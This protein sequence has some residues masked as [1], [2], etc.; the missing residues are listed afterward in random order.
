MLTAYPNGT[1]A[2]C[3]QENWRLLQR[4]AAKREIFFEEDMIIKIMQVLL[5][6]DAPSQYTNCLMVSSDLIHCMRPLMIL[7][8]Q[9][10]PLS[11]KKRIESSKRHQCISSK[12]P[13]AF[14]D[15]DKWQDT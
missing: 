15:P 4:V 9:H 7:A 2:K 1:S 8:G 3:K 14:A 6:S 12:A 10:E 11:L 5:V 13:S